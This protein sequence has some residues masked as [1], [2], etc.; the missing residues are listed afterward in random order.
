M[1]R[2]YSLKNFVLA[3]TGQISMLFG[4]ALLRFTLLMYIL[5]KNGNPISFGFIL[6][7]STF[8]LVFSEFFKII[9]SGYRKRDL[10][11]ILDLLNGV[12]VIYLLYTM[13]FNRTPGTAVVGIVLTL[14]G[15]ISAVESPNAVCLMTGLSLTNKYETSS[16][17]MGAITSF[18]SIL[19]PILGAIVKTLY[20]DL[21][22]LVVISCVAFFFASFIEAFISVDIYERSPQKYHIKQAT[23]IY[24]R[25]FTKGAGY[26]F[27][28]RRLKQSFFSLLMVNTLIIPFFLTAYPFLLRLYIKASITMFGLGMSVFQVGV[29][30]GVIG[31]GLLAKRLEMDKISNHLTVLGCLFIALTVVLTP[32]AMNYDP[33]SYVGFLV[34]TFFTLLEVCRIDFTIMAFIFEAI[35]DTLSTQ[36]LSV[37]M[38]VTVLF[39][40]I[41]QALYGQLLQSL[42]KD[43]FYFIIPLMASSLIFL[44]SFLSGEAFSSE[45]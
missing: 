28:Q 27:S 22:P 21:H 4:S 26:L 43:A 35:P 42:M 44:I 6:A 12:V 7:V 9:F 20:D 40:C 8:P 41:A 24:I 1:F 36:V 29:V 15:I 23:Q 16:A 37:V 30:I 31:I 2:E 32:N 34:L 18:A 45:K 17:F 33:F 38:S 3:I 19:A 10:L 39:M 25:D 13:A 11:V 5:D 14:L